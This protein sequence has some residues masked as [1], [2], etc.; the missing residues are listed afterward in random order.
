MGVAQ[1]QSPIPVA[2]MDA[3]NEYLREG[4]VQA[5]DELKILGVH[6]VRDIL[7]LDLYTESLR[8]RYYYDGEEFWV[9]RD[10]FIE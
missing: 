1:V 10:N 8:E 5:Y 4:R 3:W 7:D 6:R 9:K 2:S